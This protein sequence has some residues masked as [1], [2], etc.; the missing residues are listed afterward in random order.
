MSYQGPKPFGRR[1]TD[2]PLSAEERHQLQ[3]IR[4]EVEEDDSGLIR[5]YLRLAARVLQEDD[6]SYPEKPSDRRNLHLI[7]DRAA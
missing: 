6:V 4:R 7:K 2:K 5:R 3:T 1:R